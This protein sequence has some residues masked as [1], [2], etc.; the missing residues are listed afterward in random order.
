MLCDSDATTSAST[1]STVRVNEVGQDASLP[2]PLKRFR[3]LAQHVSIPNPTAPS[4]TASITDELND[5]LQGI[6]LCDTD[7]GIQWWLNRAQ[8]SSKL[9]AFAL[10]V[11]SAPSSE[12][13]VERLFSV[14]GE[15]T[16]GKRNRTL[17]SLECRVFLKL[18]RKFLPE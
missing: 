2:P 18:N 8:K 12:A 5:Y 1:A 17:Q 15:L 7:D 14:C 16:S 10:D 9:S 11:L 4:R 6:P 3:F 13:Y